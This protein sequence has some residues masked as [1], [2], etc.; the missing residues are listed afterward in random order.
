MRFEESRTAAPGHDLGRVRD[1]LAALEPE[2]RALL[3]RYYLESRSVSEIASEL[4]IPD[5][6][7]KSRLSKARN[8]L[9]R[10]LEEG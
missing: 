4:G 8:E 10:C 3:R 9:R 7:V 1:G 2:Q 6:T 5:G